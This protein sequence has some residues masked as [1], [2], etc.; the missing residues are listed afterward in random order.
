M[1][2][3][4]FAQILSY[5]RLLCYLAIVG[6]CIVSAKYRLRPPWFALML[7][8]ISVLVFNFLSFSER[9][10]L[11]RVFSTFAVTPIVT[12]LVVSWALSLY[13]QG[14]SLAKNNNNNKHKE[15]KK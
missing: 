12:F 5:W 1:N 10:G 2:N 8:F 14:K 15:H 3:E 9:E 6:M 11:A 4:L 7:F 13:E